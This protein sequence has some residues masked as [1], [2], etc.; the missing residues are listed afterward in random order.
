MR[1]KVHCKV[2]EETEIHRFYPKVGDAVKDIYFNH[3][4]WCKF[5]EAIELGYGPAFVE[6]NGYP[7][8]YTV[9]DKP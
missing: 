8:E 2:C 5:L 7:M 9:I 4:R 3:E 6:K 1:V